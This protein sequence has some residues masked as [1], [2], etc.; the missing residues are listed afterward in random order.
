VTTDPHAP[1][2]RALV[3]SLEVRLLMAHHGRVPFIVQ[4]NLV[5][6]QPGV[7]QTTD[8]N[9]VNP[10]GIAFGAPS[11]FWVNA[12]GSGTSLVE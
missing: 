3:E 7:A 6:D 11:P 9:M 5:A 12:N 1:R 10:W 8:P 4:T 2:S